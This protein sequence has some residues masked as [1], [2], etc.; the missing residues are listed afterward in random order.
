MTCREASNLL[1]LFFDGELDARQMRVIALHSTRCTNC[2]AQLRRFEQVHELVSENI[3]AAV[4][5]VDLSQLWPAIESRLGN[6]ELPWWR[7]AYARWRDG[8]YGW[9]VRVPAFAAAAAIAV[10]ALLLLTRVPQP[11]TEPAA[12]Q[13]AAVDNAASIDSLDTDVD[14]VA[15]LNDPETHTTVLWVNDESP[16]GGD[17]P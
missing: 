10:L 13:V 14:S 12:P 3:N 1:P 11:T 4:D 15:V 5:E 8:E 2:E 9:A 17:L 7:R 16:A 6:L